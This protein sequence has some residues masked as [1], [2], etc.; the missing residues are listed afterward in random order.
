MLSQQNMITSNLRV[1]TGFQACNFWVKSID[2]HFKL[3]DY[4]TLFLLVVCCEKHSWED[5]L[6]I[7]APIRMVTMRIFLVMVFILPS[8]PAELSSSDEMI[9]IS[10]QCHQLVVG[11][12]DHDRLIQCLRTGFKQLALELQRAKEMAIKQGKSESRN[13]IS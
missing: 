12:M 8:L 9:K 7:T 11:P 6:K 2:S 4:N 3:Y 10:N 13:I 1:V 5:S